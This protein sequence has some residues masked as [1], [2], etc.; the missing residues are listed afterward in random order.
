MILIG[1]FDS[2]FVRR[3]GITLQTYQVPFEHR[4][5]SV[6]RDEDAIARYNPLRRVPTLVLD[7]G[8]TLVD[9]FSILDWLDERA[10]DG[11]RLGP[12]SGPLRMQCLRATANATG[13]AD[14]VVSLFYET[15]LHP[16]PAAKWVD[17]CTRQIEAGFDALEQDH[18]SRDT[19]WWIGD[20]MSHAD[21][22]VACAIR[23]AREALPGRFDFAGRPALLAHSERC[24]ALPV[25]Q[26]VSQPFSV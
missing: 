19:V 7:D 6:W 21:V 13:V 2:P 9:S 12:P 18:R 4:P 25:F 14:K 1:Q 8:T 15:T 5:W 16:Q 24:E 22:A 17:R 23:F 3:V 10:D 26:A 20:R 11:V